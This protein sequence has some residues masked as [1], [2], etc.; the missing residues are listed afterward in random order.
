MRNVDVRYY[1]D[2]L[3]VMSFSFTAKSH[4]AFINLLRRGNFRLH[5]FQN[6]L[7]VRI[8]PGVEE[9]QHVKEK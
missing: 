7:S 4:A 8:P 9:L 5:A 6:I 1:R 2:S 3:K